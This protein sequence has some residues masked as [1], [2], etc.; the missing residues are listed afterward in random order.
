MSDERIADVPLSQVEPSRVTARSSR[1]D[2]FSNVDNDILVY[3]R[4]VVGVSMFYW[5]AKTW[6]NGSVELWFIEPRFHFRYFNFHWV[7]PWPNGWMYVHFAVLATSAICVATGFV[8]RIAALVMA[9][10]YTHIFLI[11]KTLYQN[12]YYLLCLVSWLL[13]FL[14]AAKDFSIDALIKR[15]KNTSKSRMLAE[16]WAVWLVRFMVALPYFFGGIAKINADWFACEPMR[17]MLAERTWYPVIGQYFREEWFVQLFNWGGLLFDLLIVPALLFRPT[18]LLAFGFA[19]FFHLMNATLF[20]IGVFPWFMIFATVVFIEPG[21]IRSLFGIKAQ[22]QEAVGKSERSQRSK[23]VVATL[24]ATFVS[25]QLAIPLRHFTFPGNPSWTEDGHY[26][27]WHMLLRGKLPAVRFMA[28]HKESGTVGVVPLDRYVVQHQLHRFARDPRM[29]HELACHIRSDL[30]AQGHSDF[31]IHVLALV[32]MNGR[33]PQLLLDPT[34]DLAAEPVTW[35]TPGWIIGLKEPLREQPW[36][37]PV[38]EWES[39]LGI[40]N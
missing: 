30:E 28:R 36:N 1:F 38:T 17:M 26:F 22:G 18:R 39:E 8:Y 14:P 34:I 31:A 12:H 20:T 2:L 16:R 7:K 13:V 27:S 32:S 10:C 24:L 21:Q 33:K 15:R 23:A 3:F 5:A 29:I 40:G 35:K 9:L 19:L 11:D 37:V 25:L 6:A 4:I